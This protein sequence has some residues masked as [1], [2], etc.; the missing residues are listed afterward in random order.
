M[1]TQITHPRLR[2]L[3]RPGLK[4]GEECQYRLKAA[5]AKIRK[6]NKQV[7]QEKKNIKFWREKLKERENTKEND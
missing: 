7:L 5:R 4:S 1:E 2:A 3:E 6:L